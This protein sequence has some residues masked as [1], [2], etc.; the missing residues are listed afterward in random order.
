MRVKQKRFDCLCE[1]SF[2]DFCTSLHSS[3]RDSSH[4]NKDVEESG[5]QM[6]LWTKGKLCRENPLEGDTA[7]GGRRAIR[8]N[9]NGTEKGGRDETRQYEI[10][11]KRWNVKLN[12]SDVLYRVF[13]SRNSLVC[14]LMVTRS[15]FYDTFRR[16]SQSLA[17][18]AC[19]EEKIENNSE[20]GDTRYLYIRLYSEREAREKKW[21]IRKWQKIE[22]SEWQC[23]WVVRCDLRVIYNPS[24]LCHHVRWL[25]LFT[26][27]VK[28]NICK[29]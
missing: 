25:S 21:E 18:R 2:F 11:R 16:L 9:F 3:R 24:S 10:S 4:G 20:K 22:N 6:G 17:A 19:T 8:Q 5:S 13:E 1:C 14:K 15:A 23:M 26:V 27:K 7:I 28:V 12:F 29:S